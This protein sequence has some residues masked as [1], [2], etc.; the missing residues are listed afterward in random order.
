MY[1]ILIASIQFPF[2]NL[3]VEIKSRNSITGNV[4]NNLIK[5]AIKSGLDLVNAAM[6]QTNTL[7]LITFV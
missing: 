5:L 6:I 2:L 7:K 4:K 3:R 1:A